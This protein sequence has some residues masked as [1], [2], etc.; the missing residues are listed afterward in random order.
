MNTVNPKTILAI[1]VFAC[2]LAAGQASAGLMDFTADSLQ[3]EDT[4]GC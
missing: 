1:L 4:G 3:V 2:A